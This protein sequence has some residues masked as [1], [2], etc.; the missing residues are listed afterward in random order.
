MTPPGVPYVFHVTDGALLDLSKLALSVT[1]NKPTI[2]KSAKPTKANTNGS[3]ALAFVERKMR[4]ATEGNRHPSAFALAAW[5]SEIDPPISEHEIE[6][7]IM[8]YAPHGREAEFSRAIA[9]G[10]RRG[11]A[12]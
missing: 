9:A 6:A 8:P 11:R 12:T 7:A 2:K 3:G 1:A 4:E 5:L 10:I